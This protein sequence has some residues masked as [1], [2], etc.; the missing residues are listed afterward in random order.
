MRCFYHPTDREAVA[1][2]TNCSRG[3]CSECAVDLPNATACVNRCEAEALAIKEVLERSKT[4]YQKAA[5]MHSRNALLYVLFAFVMAAIGLLT[6]PGG[7]VMVGLGAVFLVGAV[8]S[9]SSSKKFKRV[10]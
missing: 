6:L 7:W 5:Y 9:Y 3:L 10:K 8:F 4:G 1:I 2:C